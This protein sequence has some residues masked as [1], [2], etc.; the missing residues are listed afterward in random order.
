MT[1]SNDQARSRL[2]PITFPAGSRVGVEGGRDLTLPPG[3]WLSWQHVTESP[4]GG[5]SGSALGRLAEDVRVDDPRWG[6]QRVRAATLPERIGGPLC[7]L[8]DG[9][10]WGV[11]SPRNGSSFVGRLGGV[12][13]AGAARLPQGDVLAFV[14][15]MGRWPRVGGMEMEIRL[16]RSM[17]D[18]ALPW[19]VGD[20]GLRDRAL[21]EDL[22]PD[23]DGLLAAEVALEPLRRRIDAISAKLT[24]M[25]DE[26]AAGGEEFD[27]Q[28]QLERSTRRGCAWDRRWNRLSRESQRLFQQLR[29][30]EEAASAASALGRVIEA[31]EPIRRARTE[32]LARMVGA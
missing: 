19:H 10:E 15:V 14:S 27:R 32:A 31:A 12:R 5:E 18:A 26:V 25:Q 20:S 11:I 30:L 29:P 17:L 3:A 16:R 23:P 21:F 4:R 24:A 8:I 9:P 2:G 6:R 7:S 28:R 13:V 22:S 1:T